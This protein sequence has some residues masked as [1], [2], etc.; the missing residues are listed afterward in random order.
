MGA[1]SKGMDSIMSLTTV[2]NVSVGSNEVLVVIW[3]GVFMGT[4]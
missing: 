2:L 1:V 4:V 3:D